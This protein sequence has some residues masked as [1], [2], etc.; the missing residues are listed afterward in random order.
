MW[1]KHIRDAHTNAIKS[2]EKVPAEAKDQF[3]KVVNQYIGRQAIVDY[4][5]SNAACIE[6]ECPVHQAAVKSFLYV[7]HKK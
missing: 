2:W 1:A 6:G 5:L 4:L 3:A 7:R